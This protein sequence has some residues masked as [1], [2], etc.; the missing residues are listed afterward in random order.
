MR[1]VVIGLILALLAPV[2][3]V[4]TVQ[5]A[6][7]VFLETGQL[8]DPILERRAVSLG[9]TLRCVVCANQSIEDSDVDLARTLRMLVREEI[10]AG[11]SDEQIRSGLITRY[12]EYV[13]YIPATRGW[14]ILVW[15]APWLFLL[16]A[17]ILL[18]IA[19]M[20]KR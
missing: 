4:A 14:R 8:S 12:G 15:I 2:V 17:T 18:G 11:L 5:V 6:E 7:G 20:R 19:R 16:M 9:R 1:S 10:L 3:L 13:S